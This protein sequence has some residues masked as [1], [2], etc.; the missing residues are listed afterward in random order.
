M[1]FQRIGRSGGPGRGRIAGWRRGCASRP[2]T[3]TTSIFLSQPTP[4]P[5]DEWAGGLQATR[6]K[7]FA[8]ERA[9]AC[10]E[11][12]ALRRHHARHV[13]G[14]IEVARQEA[15][16]GPQERELA[17][18]PGRYCCAAWTLTARSP[19]PRESCS[20]SYSRILVFSYSRR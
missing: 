9:A 20:F 13:L 17:A 6:Q 2:P 16:A 10:G 15:K 14:V 7:E 11:L 1:D 12:E 3:L 19:R 5:H 18:L 8:L 4:R